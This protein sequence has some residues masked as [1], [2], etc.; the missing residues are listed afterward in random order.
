[1]HICFD[2]RE[3]PPYL[4]EDCMSLFNRRGIVE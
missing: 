3:Y 2:S 4:R 1:M